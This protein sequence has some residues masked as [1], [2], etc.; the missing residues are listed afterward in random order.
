MKLS[1][2][3]L[4]FVRDAESPYL[5]DA[6]GTIGDL[7]GDGH[8]DI[9]AE[10]S[11]WKL[12]ETEADGSGTSQSEDCVA[13]LVVA[14]GISPSLDLVGATFVWLCVWSGQV[15]PSEVAEAVAVEVG[16]NWK[17][18]EATGVGSGCSY[19]DEEETDLVVG[20]GNSL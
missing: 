4:D 10:G 19:M 13:V 2:R 7:D 6:V 17:L 8:G 12:I 18:M 9:E 1:V 5:V 3:I 20:L 15:A 14:V 11:N 16:S